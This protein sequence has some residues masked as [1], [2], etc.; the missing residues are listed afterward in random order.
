[1]S[2]EEWAE[3]IAETIDILRSGISILNKLLAAVISKGLP[4]KEVIGKITH[5]VAK[6]I[7]ESLWNTKFIHY[8]KGEL[9]PTSSGRGTIEFYEDIDMSPSDVLMEV[10]WL[11]G[12]AEREAMGARYDCRDL[13]IALVRDPAYPFW[14]LPHSTPHRSWNPIIYVRKAFKQ[15][16]NSLNIKRKDHQKSNT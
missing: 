16:K 9:S 15:F 2:L 7:G 12:N 4:T 13:C 3:E 8:K 11:A 6:E 10:S 5:N 14:A 1:M